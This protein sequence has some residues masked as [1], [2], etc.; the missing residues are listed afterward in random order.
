MKRIV[1]L[2]ALLAAMAAV[3]AN[4]SSGPSQGADAHKQEVKQEPRDGSPVKNSPSGPTQPTTPQPP[5][6]ETARWVLVLVGIVTAG[7]IGWQSWETRR[8]ANAMRDSIRLQEVQ[9][10]QWVE[11]GNWKGGGIISKDDND[12]T[13]LMFQ[14]DIYNPTDHG[15][16][17]GGIKWDIGG[18]QDSIEINAL[19]PPNRGHP[20]AISYA[21][22][23]DEIVRYDASTPLELTVKGLVD[24]TDMMGKE[25]NQPF[26]IHFHCRQRTGILIMKHFDTAA[27]TPPWT[28]A[29]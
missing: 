16:T 19:L 3:A 5:Q 23:S 22:T 10:K 18:Q 6:E 2:T 1:V 24:F 15:I 21:P 4:P 27:W 12:N 28:P 29:D 26:G 8:S 17:L 25:H 13:F 14:F 7:F 20:T 11:L 9:M